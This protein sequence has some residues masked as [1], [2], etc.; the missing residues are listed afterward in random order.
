MA[1]CRWRLGR[2]CLHNARKR[3]CQDAC[4]CRLLISHRVSL[5]S[6]IQLPS[7]VPQHDRKLHDF[8][9][10]VDDNRNMEMGLLRKRAS[11]A[12]RARARSPPYFAIAWVI[13]LFSHSLNSLKGAC[14]LF[15]LFF[16]THPLMPIYV[17]AVAMSRGRE[18]ILA[19]SEDDF[20]G[21]HTALKNL[22]ILAHT[23]ANQLACD[24]ILLFENFPPSKLIKASKRSGI[25]PPR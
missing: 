16:A 13:T 7:P 3:G 17:A 9:A 6:A 18:S 4:A 14:R 2:G 15:D 5:G 23:T 19:C 8:I 22:D 20:P 25:D 21:V 1:I 24:A 12:E 11:R 10:R